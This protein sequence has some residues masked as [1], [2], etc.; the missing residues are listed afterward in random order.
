MTY[1][2]INLKTAFVNLGPGHFSGGCFHAW[3]TDQC[4]R[5]T[6]WKRNVL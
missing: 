1:R 4:C 6:Q 3:N 2:R 5:T